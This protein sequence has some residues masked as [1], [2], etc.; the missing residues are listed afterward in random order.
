MFNNLQNKRAKKSIQL[1][2]YNERRVLQVLRRMGCASKAEISRSLN[3]TNAAMG[4]IVSSLEESGLVYLGK[5]RHEGGR[6]Q[7]ATLI[8][9]NG[10]GVYSIGVQIDRSKIE[11]ILIDFDGNIISRVKDE[12]ILPTPKQ[13]LEIVKKDIEQILTLLDDEKKKRLAGIGLAIPYN[14]DSWTEVL[15][16][17][18]DSFTLWKDYE[19]AKNLEELVGIPV[20]REND[21]TSAAIAALYYGVGRDINDFLYLYI[22]PGIGGGLVLNGEIVS[23]E[24]GNAADVG[25]MPV[26]PSSLKSTKRPNSTFDIMLNRA[27]INV[28]IKHLKYN[29][30]DVDSQIQLESIIS[31][32]NKYFQEW[33]DDSIDA[34]THLIWSSTTLLDIST[35]VIASAI[36]GDL[37][38]NVKK[39]LDFSLSVN[40]PESCKVPKIITGKFGSDAGAIGAASLPIFY[41]F[42][43]TKEILT[44]G[45]KKE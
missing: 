4:S 1:R 18:K 7:P 42:S 27:S 17:P 6:G 44:E 34:L 8:H 37:V 38:S 9:L 25:S 30:I 3:L 21:G 12:R 15:N 29:G 5:K 33:L 40:A 22:G 16:L 2:L 14:L 43:P 39:K 10:K 23:G 26:P 41:S 35:I 36:D 28:L 13:T 32:N 31:S 19:F 11:T 24:N 45:F 20:Y